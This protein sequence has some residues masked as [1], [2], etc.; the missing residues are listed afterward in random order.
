MTD[1]DTPALQ[2]SLPARR[3]CARRRVMMIVAA[4]LAVV[5]IGAFAT[6]SF[7]QGFGGFGP[8]FGHFGPGWGGP[9]AGGPID[10]AWIEA[11]LGRMIRHLAVE[12]DATAEQQQKLQA[13]VT[14][15]AKDVLPVR[16]KMWAARR[17]TR[18]LLTQTT[19]DRAALEKLRAEQIAT[20][21]A[22][23]KRVLQAV[24][25]AAEVLTPDQRKKLAEMLPAG[26]RGPGWGWR[27]PGWGMGR[28]GGFWGGG[29]RN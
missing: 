5:L 27:G 1:H 17:Q 24:A 29:P 28:M 7:S 22:T 6:T 15:A 18:E 2:T 16:E 3:P 25:D 12:L 20:A 21:D 26:G 23:S 19:V 4:A 9:F 14:A 13:I 10:P 11:R 8:G